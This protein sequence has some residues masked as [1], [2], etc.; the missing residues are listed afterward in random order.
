MNTGELVARLENVIP[1][2][3]IPVDHHRELRAS[4]LAEYNRIQNQR[5]YKGLFGWVWA[6][7][8]LWRTALITSAV[9]AVVAFVVVGID[10][11]PV[12]QPYSGTA[13]TVGAV[14]A[15][16]LVRATLAGDEMSSVTVTAL[17]GDML[18][19]VVESRGGA[20]IIVMVNTKYN[21]VTVTDITY[22]ILFGSIYEPE[23][24]ITGEE[25][26]KV[27]NI[28]STDHTF[29]SIMEKG[30]IINKTTAIE[31]V[32]ST[33]HV[34]TGETIETRD[35]WAMVELRLE[36]KRWYFLVDPAGSRVI[37]R[38]ITPIP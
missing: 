21:L 38:S 12:R 14:M 23:R 36:T 5:E 28:A 32:V 34:A 27:I 10:L 22:I 16:P 35:Q 30:A 29:R 2:D 11:L 1:P 3:V 18:E 8:S 31:T 26:Q 25:Q 37:N 24:P 13:Q 6:R 15:N 20:M 17:G 9:W 7:P 4:L 19:V 33:R